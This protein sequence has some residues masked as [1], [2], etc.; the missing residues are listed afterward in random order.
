MSDKLTTRDCDE[1]ADELVEE[2]REHLVEF[3]ARHP[4][5]EPIDGGRVVEGWMIQKIANLQILVEN[6]YRE[7]PLPI[8]TDKLAGPRLLDDGE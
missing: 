6:L 3:T 8:S 4:E 2:F 1:R 7:P 5:L